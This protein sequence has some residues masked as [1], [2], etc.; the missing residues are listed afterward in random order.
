M[1]LLSEIITGDIDNNMLIMFIIK[2]DWVVSGMLVPRVT[3]GSS[4]AISTK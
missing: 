3:Q 2:L 1:W 4:M